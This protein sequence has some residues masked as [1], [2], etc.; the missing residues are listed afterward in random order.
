LV[1]CCLDIYVSLIALE[2]HYIVLHLIISVVT[3]AFQAT[4]CLHG[5]D[6]KGHQLCFG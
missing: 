4:D 1:V 3:D 2:H 6:F 5:L